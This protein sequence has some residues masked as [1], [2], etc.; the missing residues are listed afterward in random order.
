MYGAWLVSKGRYD[1]F[2]SNLFGPEDKT[3]ITPAH[4][5]PRPTNEILGK[6]IVQTEAE[7]KAE[8][9]RLRKLQEQEELRKAAEAEAEERERAKRENS[10]FNK[11]V[12]GLKNFFRKMVDDE[13]EK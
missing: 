12:K 9:E 7:K 13:E 6:G 5:E 1:D 10:V 4:K 3:V 8:E 11:S 2:S